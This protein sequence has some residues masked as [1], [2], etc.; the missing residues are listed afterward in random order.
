MTAQTKR[1]ALMTL[2]AAC[3]LLVAVRASQ[4]FYFQE[5]FFAFLLFAAGFVILL[6]AAALAVGLWFLYARGVIYLAARTVEQGH[7]ALPL[8]RVLVLWLAPTVTKT[9]GFV[10]AGQQVLFYPFGG[11]LHGWLRSLRSDA[12]HFRE[13]AERAVKH[14]R[15]LLKQS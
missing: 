15:L 9:A 11:L 3:G 10:S 6:L 2:M 14:L 12:F 7:H 13:D 8:L 5:L 1:R 4:V